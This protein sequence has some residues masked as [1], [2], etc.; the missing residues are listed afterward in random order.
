MVWS[1]PIT[2]WSWKAAKTERPIVSVMCGCWP[3]HL[4]ST[5]VDHCSSPDPNVLATSGHVVFACMVTSA[6]AYEILWI[7][8]TCGHWKTFESVSW[9]CWHHGHLW[10]VALSIL[11]QCDIV[12]NRSNSSLKMVSCLPGDEWRPAHECAPQSMV[13]NIV[14]FGHPA[15]WVTYLINSSPFSN[16][17]LIYLPQCHTV[18]R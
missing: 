14:L 15:F 16:L 3:C 13:W 18:T 10:S 9:N 5:E 17:N 8:L 7:S 2:C 6:F 1:H 11:W 12:A 4:T